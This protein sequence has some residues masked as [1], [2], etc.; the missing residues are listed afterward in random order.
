MGASQSRGFGTKDHERA[1]LRKYN[2]NTMIVNTTMNPVKKQMAIQKLLQRHE[3]TFRQL[4]STN[5]RMRM[6]NQQKITKL[7]TQITKLQ[8]RIQQMEAAPEIRKRVINALNT[9][10]KTLK[11]KQKNIRF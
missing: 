9:H 8:T 2:R 1:Q 4:S 10:V 7:K 11:N 6:R 5:G 3:K